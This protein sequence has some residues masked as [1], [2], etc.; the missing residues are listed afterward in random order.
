[1]LPQLQLGIDGFRRHRRKQPDLPPRR[2]LTSVLPTQS[3]FMTATGLTARHDA[4]SIKGDDRVTHV[5][6]AMPSQIQ[7]QLQ[8]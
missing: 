4:R 5:G 2:P 6:A 1:M 8:G 3:S 7:L